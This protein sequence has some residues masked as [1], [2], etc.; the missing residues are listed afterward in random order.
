MPALLALYGASLY[1][2]GTAA[3]SRL[4]ASGFA[5]AM[6]GLGLPLAAAGLFV[7]TF[8]GAAEELGRARELGGWPRLG[9]IAL[10][11]VALASAAA[12]VASRR[13]SAW[14][15][16]AALLATTLLFLVP[17]VA[18][19]SERA[20][21]GYAIAFNVVFAALALGCLYAGYANEESWLVN[22]G[23]ALVAVDVI[24]RYFDLFWDALPRSLG[25][26]GA[27]L[28]VLAI[29]LLLERQRKRL[30]QRMRA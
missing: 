9:L 15:E 6:R 3:R 19:G 30:L 16:A 27:G 21:V 26:I 8:S 12:L 7:F 1:G 22:V 28:L 18:G 4:A 29:A 20:G 2:L 23:V 24:G 25:L 11:L 5:P 17:I 13:R 10:V 14:P